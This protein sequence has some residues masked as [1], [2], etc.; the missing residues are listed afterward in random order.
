MSKMELMSSLN[1]LAQMRNILI[2]G[3]LSIQ[4]NGKCRACSGKGGW[5]ESVCT[6]CEGSGK[7]VSV[8]KVIE[9]ANKLLPDVLKALDKIGVSSKCD[10][11]HLKRFTDVDEKLYPHNIS[12]IWEYA[13]EHLTESN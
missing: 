9:E 7:A 2:E 1:K 3:Q 10:R 5:G 4:G 13:R 12:K 6:I 11:P 8:S